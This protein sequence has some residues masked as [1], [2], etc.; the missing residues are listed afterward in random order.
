MPRKQADPDALRAPAGRL[1][2]SIDDYP[3]LVVLFLVV[4]AVWAGMPTVCGG[5]DVDVPMTARPQLLPESETQI[6]ITLRADGQL[7]IGDQWVPE[8][9][10]ARRMADMYEQNP[11]RR[12]CIKADRQLPFR[13]VQRIIAGV[14]AAGFARLGFV[15][16]KVAQVAVRPG[17]ALASLTG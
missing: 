15:T 10:F 16:R 5:V 7:F 4:I 11:G 2:C 3:L 8:E 14:Q 12:V 9:H 17:R 1:I 13:K 6:T